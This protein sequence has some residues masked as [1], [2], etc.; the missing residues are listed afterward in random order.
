MRPLLSDVLLIFSNTMTC[1]FIFSC[2]ASVPGTHFFFPSAGDRTQ[3]LID[4]RQPLL[5]LSVFLAL[6][7][8]SKW[9]PLM[10]RY[11]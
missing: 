4:A 11:F 1:L 9:Y 10:G 8:F 2:F 5:Q 3:A 7:S 6:F